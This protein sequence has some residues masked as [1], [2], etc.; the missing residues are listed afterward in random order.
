M[1][2]DDSPN[3]LAL[4]EGF[5]ED[6]DSAPADER[7][8]RVALGLYDPAGVTTVAERAS[9]APDTARR[10]LNRLADIGVVEVVSETP[11]TYTRNESYFEWRQRN[12]LENRSS[13]ELQELLS[14]LTTR[15]REFRDQF[16]VD[17]PDK[18]DAL[19]HADFDD[20]ETVWLDLSEW[21]TVRERI[22]RL[23][24]VRQQRATE[25]A[26]DGEPA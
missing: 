2:A 3:K 8:Y 23:E 4:A 12:R 17:A 6:V 26:S 10:H 22:A 5:R 16:G 20:V 13:S 19:E 18:V 11:L 9:C 24:A 21:Q 25:S 14:E 7:V 15:E 1:N